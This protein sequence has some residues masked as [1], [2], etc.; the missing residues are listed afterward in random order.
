M[1]TEWCGQH[2]SQ[3]LSSGDARYRAI[4]QDY[5]LRYE[6][7][8]GEFEPQSYLNYSSVNDWF[9][10]NI[11][12]EFRPTAPGLHDIASPADARTTVWNNN[13]QGVKFWIK[14]RQKHKR[15]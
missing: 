8:M 1:S 9:V 2:Y 11:R 14:G 3:Y 7:D 4:Q 10:R 6:V 13:P 12:T 5:V 15:D